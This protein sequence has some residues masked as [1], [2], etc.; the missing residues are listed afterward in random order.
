MPRGSRPAILD[1]DERPTMMS[2][3][4]A[5]MTPR[6]PLR[7]ALIGTAFMG[8]AHSQAWRTAPRFFDLPREPELAL[9]V[10]RSAE[11]TAARATQLGWQDWSTNWR[12]AVTRDDIDVIDICSPGDTH[13]EIA[14]AALAAGKHVLCE[15][16]LAN[17]VADAVRMTDAAERAGRNGVLSMCGFSYRRTPALALARRMIAEGRLG[18]IRHVRASYL[19]DWLSDPE[20]PL[21]WRLDK[22]KAGSGA[23]GDIGAHSIDTAQ[24]LL[25]E[26]ITEVSATL[27]TFV[28]E[29]P[30]RSVAAGLG[31]VA[32]PGAHRGPVTVDDAVAFT[33]GFSGGALGVF[34]ATRMATGR[35]NANRIEVNGETGSIAFDFE[36]MNE[37]EYFDGRGTDPAAEG[38]RRI[39]VTDAVHPYV[40]NWWPTG[41]GLGYEHLF[42]HQVVDFVTAIG[43][44]TAPSPSFGE[45][46][47]VQRVLAAVETSA[48][49]RSQMTPVERMTP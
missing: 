15:K 47:A 2:I 21:S 1:E 19:Q 27:R 48:S 32:A 24:W 36:R 9:L 44:G 3:E 13:V 7:V 18:T 49:T 28:S 34:E 41:H 6:T 23:L 31:G 8:A 11:T 30:E 16:P 42:T 5:R 40:A 35:R 33:A 4:G 43:A 38:F 25:G 37:L 10:G 22:A 20:S 29:R 12:D 26:S 17:S 39:V 14:L 46:L 45:A